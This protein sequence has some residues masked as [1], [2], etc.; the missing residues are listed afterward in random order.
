[1]APC[2]PSF[3][4]KPGVT[5]VDP[6][7][8]RLYLLEER[9]WRVCQPAVL[10]FPFSIPFSGFLASARNECVGIFLPAYFFHP[11]SYKVGY[12]KYLDNPSICHFNRCLFFSCSFCRLHGFFSLKV[13]VICFQFSFGGLNQCAHFLTTRESNPFFDISDIYLPLSPLQGLLSPLIPFP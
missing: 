11:S 7:A 10:H 1:M 6:E 4:R 9:C 3:A 2:R 13:N 5:P 12:Y 8:G